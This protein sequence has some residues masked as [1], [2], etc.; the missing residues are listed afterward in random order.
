MLNDIAVAFNLQMHINK[1]YTSPIKYII[2][3]W[4]FF[5]NAAVKREVRA[6]PLRK[7]NFFAGFQVIH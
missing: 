1:T 4:L 6:Y 2:T 5:F 3:F 7:K